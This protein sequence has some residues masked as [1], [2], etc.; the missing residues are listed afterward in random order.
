MHTIFCDE[1]L[2]CNIILNVN[3]GIVHDVPRLSL[4]RGFD[5]CGCGFGGCEG[6]VGLGGF[7]GLS[8]FGRFDGLGN[9]TDSADSADSTDS[10][11]L[12]DSYFNLQLDHLGYF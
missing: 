1:L 4:K 8:G 5:G 3:N 2:F 11:D 7:N 6:L 10:A 12:A 9:S